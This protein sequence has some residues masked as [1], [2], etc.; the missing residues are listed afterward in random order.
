MHTQHITRA[1]VHRRGGQ[2]SYLL[3]ARGQFGTTNMNVT[4]VECPPGSQQARH[5]H[6]SQEQVYVIIRGR[7]VMIVGDEEQEVGEGTLISVPPWMPHAIRNDGAETMVYV[8]ATSPPFD[9]ALLY[10]LDARS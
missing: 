10:E 3:L 8:S 2:L 4:W 1:P 5:E 9:E 7:G 6:A